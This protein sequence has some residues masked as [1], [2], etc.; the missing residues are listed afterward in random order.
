MNAA[1]DFLA[2]VQIMKAKTEPATPRIMRLLDQLSAYSFNLYFVKGKDMVWVDYFTR[3]RESHDDPYELVPVSFCCFEMYLSHLGLDTLNVYST[4]S[5]TKEADVIEAEVH[6][7]NKGTLD[8]FVTHIRQVAALL[9]YGEPHIL[10]VF[11]NTLPTRLYWVLFPIEDLRQVV[12]TA[13]EY[14]SKKR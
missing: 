12:E 4:I 10:E 8:M 3:H 1:V 11:K 2:V 13:K 6:G 9:G 7:I 14:Y 5:K